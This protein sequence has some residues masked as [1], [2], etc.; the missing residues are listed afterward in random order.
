MNDRMRDK[1]NQLIHQPVF[2]LIGLVVAWQIF[3]D[4]FRPVSS[5]AIDLL[6]PGVYSPD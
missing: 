2:S 1:W 3:G 5:L 6:Y 4:I